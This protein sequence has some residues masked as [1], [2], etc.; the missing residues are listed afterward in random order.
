MLRVSSILLLVARGRIILLITWGRIILLDGIFLSCVRMRL[1]KLRVLWIP[2]I[3]LL[4]CVGSFFVL[5]AVR[6]ARVL[7]VFVWLVWIG[8]NALM[9]RIIPVVC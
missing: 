4:R 9:L 7:H 5:E 2:V 6:I 3:I 8:C 1:V